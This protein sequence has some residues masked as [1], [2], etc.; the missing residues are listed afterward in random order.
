M[1]GQVQP[2]EREE[3]EAFRPIEQQRE[4]NIESMI[5]PQTA[6]GQPERQL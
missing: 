4:P 3:P 1:Y 2:P 5:A 6:D